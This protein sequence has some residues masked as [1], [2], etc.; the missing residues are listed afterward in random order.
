MPNIFKGPLFPSWRSRRIT[1]F[2]GFPVAHG[3]INEQD[4]EDSARARAFMGRR[5]KDKEV[6]QGKPVDKGG[7]DITEIAIDECKEVTEEDYEIAIDECKE[8]TEEDYEKVREW[9]EQDKASIDSQ[10]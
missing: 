8:V 6:T 10:G 4:F 3:V 5:R 9:A 7:D 2:L 1:G